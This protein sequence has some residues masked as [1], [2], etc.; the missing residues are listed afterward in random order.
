MYIHYTENKSQL[1][2]PQKMVQR[3]NRGRNKRKKEL[4]RKAEGLS[5]AITHMYDTITKTE[6]M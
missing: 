3:K 6:L 2:H 4:S 5:L 1:Q